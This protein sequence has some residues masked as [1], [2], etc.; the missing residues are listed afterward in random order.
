MKII[1]HR[2]AKGLAPENTRQSLLKALEHHVDEIEFDLR[3]CKDNV[4]VL[5]HNA[6]VRINDQKLTIRETDFK[7]LQ[8]LDLELLTLIEAL[9]ILRGKV[10]AH[11]EVKSRQPVEPIVDVVRTALK[12]GNYSS[13]QI[14]IGSLSQKVLVQLRRALPTIQLIV[15]EPWSGMRA[16]WR[17]KQVQT[18]YLSMNHRWLWR[19]FIE[20]LSRR[21]WQLY[22]YTLN[23]PAK[24]KRFAHYGLYG[25]ITDYPDLF[26]K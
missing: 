2:G 18:K 20:P 17:A 26:E 21:G 1:G 15:I 16:T 9:E 7:D 11:I 12:S 14:R 10:I 8:A 5:H 6:D 23:N 3:V 4:V 24:A 22:C 19:G 25:V 13:E